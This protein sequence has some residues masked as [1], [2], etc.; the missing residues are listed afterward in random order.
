MKVQKAMG[1][2]DLQTT[3]GYYTFVRADLESLVEP[4]ET[5]KQEVAELKR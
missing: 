1:H 2:S 5:E 3:M 4:E